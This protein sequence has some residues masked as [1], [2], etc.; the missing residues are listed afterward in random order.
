MVKTKFKKIKLKTFLKK[1]K[2][3]NFTFL[4][5]FYKK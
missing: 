5:N 1:Y 2:K 4:K 3:Y